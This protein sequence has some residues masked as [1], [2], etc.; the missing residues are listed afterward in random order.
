MVYRPPLIKQLDGSTFAGSNCTMASAAMSA[1]RYHKGANPK[2]EGSPWYP[3][4]RFIRLKTGDK[5]GGTTLPQADYVVR[6]SYEANLDVILG[7]KW[8]NVRER[9]TS[10][11][12]AILQGSYS[13]FHGTS[14][15][16]SGT[17]KGNH[18]IFVNE[19][20]WNES[21]NRWDFLVYDPLAD[22]RRSGIYTGPKWCSDSL[23]AKF[24]GKLDTN[25]NGAILGLGR[26]YVG[27]TRDT[28]DVIVKFGAS[29]ITRKSLTAKYNH[30]NVRRAPSL[31]SDVAYQ[32]NVSNHDT[33]NA[34]QV[35]TNGPLVSGSRKWYGDING[36]KWVAAKNF[37]GE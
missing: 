15:D 35:K 13:V 24:A 7:D 36:V 27:Y 21:Q 1:V 23:L 6:H 3:T 32:V 11:E 12:G 5:S 18:A 28:E 9:I 22:G 31:S 29:K 20:R 19:I 34:Y 26:A 4:P 25:G 10:G 30:I 16:A 33:F 37:V 14:M 8:E 2:V 17:F